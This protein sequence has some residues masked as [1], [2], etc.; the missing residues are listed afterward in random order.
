MSPRTVSREQLREAFSF[1]V[2]LGCGLHKC[3]DPPMLFRFAADTG[4]LESSLARRSVK[5]HL[6]S[7]LDNLSLPR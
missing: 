7:S 6:P 2:N 4:V 5:C 3:F 1:Y